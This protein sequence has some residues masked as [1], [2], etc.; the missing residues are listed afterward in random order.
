MVMQARKADVQFYPDRAVARAPLDAVELTNP[1]VDVPLLIN[2]QILEIPLFPALAAAAGPEDDED[3][4]ESSPAAKDPGPRGKGAGDRPATKRAERKEVRVY[5][6]D[7]EGAE[8][9]IAAL[10]KML[11]ELKEL[12]ARSAELSDRPAQERLEQAID[13]LKEVLQKQRTEV[14]A[15][16]E[17]ERPKPRRPETGPGPKSEGAKEGAEAAEQRAEIARLKAEVA[18]RQKALMEAQRRLAEAM[19]RQGR[20]GPMPGPM[21]RGERFEFRFGAPGA[22]P[23]EQEQSTRIVP[24]SDQDRRIAELEERLGKLQDEVKSLKKEAPA[25]K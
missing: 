1:R 19:R 15:R 20:P 17:A 3:D 5:R 8:R 21:A 14:A 13:R 4:D 11:A 7:K 25:A 9:S 16:P 6:L 12:A 18:E 22:R 10:E 23:F 2:D 24:R